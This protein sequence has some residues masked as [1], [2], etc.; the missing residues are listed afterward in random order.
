M[1]PAQADLELAENR[2]PL[3]ERCESLVSRDG[4]TGSFQSMD[5]T[6]IKRGFHVIQPTD[7]GFNGLVQGQTLGNHVVFAN[8]GGF[9]ITQCLDLWG[10]TPTCTENA[11]GM[12]MA[13]GLWPMGTS[14][15]R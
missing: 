2:I 12:R 9:P 8:N 15:G 5:L 1:I 13:G 4:R 14:C 10:R 6:K 3:E 7:M 11:R